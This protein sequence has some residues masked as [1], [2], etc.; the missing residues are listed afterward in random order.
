ML[1]RQQQRAKNG[2]FSGALSDPHLF[3]ATPN[4]MPDLLSFSDE[5]PKNITDSNITLIEGEE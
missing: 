2:E 1:Q 3:S 4:N 5:K